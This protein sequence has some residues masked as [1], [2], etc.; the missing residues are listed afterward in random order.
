MKEFFIA[1]AWMFLW[2]RTPAKPLSAPLA[3][4]LLAA[5]NALHSPPGKN[6]SND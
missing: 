5:S 6:V 3:L 1:M 2:V 4:R